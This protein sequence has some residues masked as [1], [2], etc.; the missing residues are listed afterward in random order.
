M[1]DALLAVITI[2]KAY[3]P[4]TTLTGTRIYRSADIPTTPQKPFIA[5]EWVDRVPEPPTSSSTYT[6]ARIQVTTFESSSAKAA[7]LSDLIGDALM[8][9]SNLITPISGVEISDIEDR[10]AVPD[11]SDGQTTGTYRDNHDFMI[12]YRLR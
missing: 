9:D 11:N 8:Q 2:L 5:A 12:T 10:G 6:V 7:I 1:K 4:I 3:T